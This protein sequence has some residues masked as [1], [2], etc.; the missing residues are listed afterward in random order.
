LLPNAS[1]PPTIAADTHPLAVRREVPHNKQIMKEDK[2]RYLTI[3]F[4]VLILIIGCDYDNSTDQS[5]LNFQSLYGG[6]F[7]LEVDRISGAPH[8]QFPM[9][10]LQESDYE[11]L[12]EVIVY[13]VTFSEDGQIVVIEPGSIYGQKTNNAVESTSYQL[14]EGTFAGGRFIVWI[15]NGGFEAELTIYGSGLPIVKSERG[16]LY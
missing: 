10:D 11:E 13:D 15:N 12:N 14:G 16:Y 7:V 4:F 8:V 9:D 2:M 1:R 5:D 6:N 3:C